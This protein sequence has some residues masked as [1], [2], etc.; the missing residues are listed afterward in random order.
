LGPDVALNEIGC[1]GVDF[2]ELVNRSGGVPADLSGWILAAKP[3][4]P[5]SGYAIPQGTELAPG[6]RL[7]FLQAKK[8]GPG[9]LPWDIDCGID[10]ISVLDAAGKAVDSIKPD[11]VPAYQSWGRLPDLTGTWAPN[12]PTPGGPNEPPS[13]PAAQVFDPFRMPTVDLT[14]SKAS[15][16]ALNAD[17]FTW[18]EGLFQFTD[19]LGASPLM[20]VGIRLKGQGSSFQ[21]LDKKPSFKVKFTH[22]DKLQR[23]RGLKKLTLNNG[24][25]DCSGIHELLIYTLARAAEIPSPRWGYAWVR[26]NGEVYGLYGDVESIDDVFCDRWFPDTVHLYEDNAAGDLKPGAVPGF[27]VQVGKKSDTTDLEALI[28]TANTAADATWSESMAGVAD[29]DEMTREWALEVLTGHWDGYAGSA[30]NYY[31]HSLKTGVFSMIPWGADQTLALAL[32]FHEGKGY[33]FV[34]CMANEPCRKTYDGNMKGLLA[35]YDTLD[36][37]GLAAEAAVFLDPWVQQDPRKTCTYE[38]WKTAVQAGRDFLKA[39]RVE[40]GKAFQ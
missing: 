37:D 25:G 6:G 26:V 14:L 38:E 35:V 9:V 31:L 17:P 3:D 27:E 2:I 34:R 15:I 10:V 11:S 36:L 23:F 24:F 30:N 40:A 29:L 1:H 28:A 5:A 21:T 18:V 12:Q 32:P 33:L 16:D 20:T 19:D 39:R 8:D 7:V 13:D 22:V 4:D